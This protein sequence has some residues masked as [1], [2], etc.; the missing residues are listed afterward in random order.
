MFRPPR[1]T[2]RPTVQGVQTALVVGPKGE[3]IYTDKYGRVKV[4][5]FWDYH[6][7]KVYSTLT[8]L[9]SLF[10][11]IL[12]IL[13]AL[14]IAGRISYQATVLIVY[15]LIVLYVPLFLINGVLVKDKQLILETDKL[16][17]KLA[18][19]EPLGSL[20]ELLKVEQPETFWVEYKRIFGFSKKQIFLITILLLG[21]L[22]WGLL[23]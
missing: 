18:R 17:G 8:M 12:V 5:F 3:E 4:Q 16:L 9:V 11:G 6:R 19:V 7:T 10:I 21:I 15:V 23:H 20:K 1:V 2:P 13:N 22:V 14:Q